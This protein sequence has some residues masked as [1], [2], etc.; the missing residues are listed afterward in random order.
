[1][2]HDHH[3]EQLFMFELF[4]VSVPSFEMCKWQIQPEQAWRSQKNLLEKQNLTHPPP[5]P[6]P[7]LPFLPFSNGSSLSCAHNSDNF[8]LFKCNCQLKFVT[9]L[10]YLTTLHIIFSFCAYFYTFYEV[11]CRAT[12]LRFRQHC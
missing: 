6:P 7:I 9:D 11:C 3:V 1:M 4:S 10:L 12:E 8:L 5:S 2:H